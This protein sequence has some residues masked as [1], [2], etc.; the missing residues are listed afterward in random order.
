M[1]K[2]KKSTFDREMKDLKFK[3]AFY[4]NY[5]DF[6]LS[7]LIIALME[8]DEKSVRQLAKETHLSA[9][10]IQNIRSQKQTDLKLSNF[11]NIVHA[12][13]YQVTLERGNERISL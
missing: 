12:F 10:M 11:L 9:T 1:I 4:E 6:L 3:K 8:R 7:E 13:G 5:K 2:T